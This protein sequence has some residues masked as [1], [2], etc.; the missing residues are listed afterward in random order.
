MKLIEVVPDDLGGLRRATVEHANGSRETWVE[1]TRGMWRDAETA[2]FVVG[3]DSVQ[4]DKLLWLHAR[5]QRRKDPEPAVQYLCRG[6]PVRPGTANAA[7]L[8][9]QELARVRQELDG[10][11][12]T[13]PGAWAY[14]RR[15]GAADTVRPG[16]FTVDTTRM[17]SAT[18]SEGAVLTAEAIA[19]MGGPTVGRK[20]RHEVHLHRAMAVCVIESPEP[21]EVRVDDGVACTGDL[22]V[23]VNPGERFVYV[24]PE[25][26]TAALR[27][28]AE[29]V[30]AELRRREEGP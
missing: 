14:S 23:K 8:H 15:E 20:E 13:D 16:G 29:A 3:S 10:A 24:S 25:T 21:V 19:R 1:L 5:E 17:T 30:A 26:S 12:M 27:T 6:M 11:S 4:L 18:K 7:A 22:L 2:E 9:Q 28:L